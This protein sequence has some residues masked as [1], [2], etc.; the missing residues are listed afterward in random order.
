M[1]YPENTLVGQFDGVSLWF[2]LAVGALLLAALGGLGMSVV[3]W[4]RTRTV[5][6]RRRRT[7]RG[8]AV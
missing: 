7:E 2:L 5:K 8:R 4:F 1:S 3:L 6:R